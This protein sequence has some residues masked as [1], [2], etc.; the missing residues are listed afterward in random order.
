MALNPLIRQLVIDGFCLIAVW[1]PVLVLDLVG[2]SYRRGFYCDDDSIRYPFFDS[3]VSTVV[4]FTV[5]AGIP[6]AVMII[7]E[8][9][10]H[11]YRNRS[12]SVSSM[13]S[14]Y[15]SDHVTLGR[16]RIPKFV[17]EIVHV[18]AIFVFGAGCNQLVTDCGKYTIGRLRPHFIAVCQPSNLDTLCARQTELHQYITDYRCT[19]EDLDRIKDSRLSFPSGHASFSAYAM[20]YLALYLQAR[21]TWSGSYMLRPLLQIGA[22]L[23]SW[24]TGLSRVSDYKHHWSDVLSGFLIG[25]ITAALTARYVAMLFQKKK[26]MDEE[27]LPETRA[28]MGLV[29]SSSPNPTTNSN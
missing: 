12:S 26:A 11:W 1:V 14:A 13:R 25:S 21:M 16:L 22:L 7:V 4:L 2:K 28:D 19:G 8:S 10:R 5:G 9:E 6:V 20:L 18:V 3:T 24:L 29:E 15:R 27:C 17:V 23:L